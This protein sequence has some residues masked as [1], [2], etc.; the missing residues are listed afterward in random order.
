MVY[1]SLHEWLTTPT[2]GPRDRA[3]NA[4]VVLNLLFGIL[5]NIALIYAYSLKNFKA[6]IL[7]TVLI[8]NMLS[9]LY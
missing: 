1:F 4:K 5:T 6:H 2:R 8:Q 3:T 9:L 7:T